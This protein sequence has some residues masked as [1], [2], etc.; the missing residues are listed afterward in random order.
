M[1]A[2]ILSCSRNY[3]RKRQLKPA[4]KAGRLAAAKRERPQT[5]FIG[6][7][8]GGESEMKTCSAR[9]VVGG[10]QAATMRFNARAADTESHTDS[11]DLRCKRCIN[12]LV[13]LLRRQP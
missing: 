3:L 12:D 7:G 4:V 10:P 13:R 5:S 11:L 8:F 1:S 6:L 2:V 9:R